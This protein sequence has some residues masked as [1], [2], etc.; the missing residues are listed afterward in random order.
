MASD[1]GTFIATEDNLDAQ[2]IGS[3]C[4]LDRY[5]DQ[6]IDCATP[7]DKRVPI[8]SELECQQLC[9]ENLLS[10]CKSFQ[11]DI[12]KKN[13]DLYD[14]SLTETGPGPIVASGAQLLS[15]DL[16]PLSSYSPQNNLLASFLG[17]K[18]DQPIQKGIKG[19][20]LKSFFRN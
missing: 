13:C 6:K 4:T 19:K 11:Y 10:L 1:R 3:E 16:V 9:L 5:E 15:T 12:L 8:S 17:I 7:F 2:E 18:K 14:V 20:K